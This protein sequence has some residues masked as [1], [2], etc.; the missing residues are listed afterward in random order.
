MEINRIDETLNAKFD[1]LVDNEK[2]LQRPCIY[3]PECKCSVPQL[4]FQIC[5]SCAS[6]MKYVH[7]DIVPSIFHKIKDLAISLK[8]RMGL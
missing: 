1:H 3:Y 7:N 8:Q 2:A 6:G 5:R 4:R